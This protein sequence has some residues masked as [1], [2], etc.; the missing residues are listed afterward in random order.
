MIE[1]T[2][3]DFERMKFL[4]DQEESSPSQS[5]VEADDKEKTE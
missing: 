1:P 5:T 4:M 2:L 3:S